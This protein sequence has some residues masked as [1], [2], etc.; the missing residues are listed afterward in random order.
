M[1]PSD[2][3]RDDDVFS[4]TLRTPATTLS[5]SACLMLVSKN[6]P[7]PAPLKAL[8]AASSAPMHC[9]FSV[10]SPLY[11]SNALSRTA[12][13]SPCAS[14]FWAM[15]L[16]SCWISAP[17]EAISAFNLMIKA[18]NSSIFASASLMSL[19]LRAIV[20]SHQHAYLSY[21]LCSDLP[22]VSMVVLSSSNKV[23]T[24]A[25]GESLTS[26]NETA[27]CA[28]AARSSAARA[29]RCIAEVAASESSQRCKSQMA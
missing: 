29:L 12:F 15:S 18:C 4:R 14:M 7:A 24:C 16:L 6:L 27:T 23:T 26:F 17:W 22:S 11:S 20:D 8:T 25:T 28:E 5:N 21:E 3:P 10:F 19:A 2:K 9:S 13:A 1:S